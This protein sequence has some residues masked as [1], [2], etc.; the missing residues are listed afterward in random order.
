MYVGLFVSRKRRLDV[1]LQQ[2]KIFNFIFFCNVGLL[3]SCNNEGHCTLRYFA[4]NAYMNCYSTC[5]T[6]LTVA[7]N[8]SWHGCGVS[9]CYTMSDS[10]AVSHECHSWTEVHVTEAAIYHT[11][12]PTALVIYAKP[13]DFP[14]WHISKLHISATIKKR[15]NGAK[16]TRIPEPIKVILLKRSPGGQNLQ[17]SP[18]LSSF[19]PPTLFLFPSSSPSSNW[20]PSYPPLCYAS[21]PPLPLITLFGCECPL[22]VFFFA[23]PP[24]LPESTVIPWKHCRQEGHY[25]T[26]RITAISHYSVFFSLWS[27]FWGTEHLFIYC[28]KYNSTAS[29]HCYITTITKEQRQ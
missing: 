20:S 5:A 24:P 26:L 16:S 25:N 18:S 15:A 6:S 29:D 9:H 21:Y 8:M 17:S 28:T 3:M 14:K 13:G 7:T 2:D 11:P 1:V 10:H 23:S 27:L 22:S 4:V 12:L 19:I